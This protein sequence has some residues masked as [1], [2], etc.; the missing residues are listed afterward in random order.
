MLL[1]VSVRKIE[2]ITRCEL[3]E[4]VYKFYVGRKAET[5][6]EFAPRRGEREREASRSKFGLELDGLKSVAYGL[7]SGK[8]FNVFPTDK[9]A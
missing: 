4:G 9:D 3:Y 1:L 6:L 5:V 7:G 2:I 8:L